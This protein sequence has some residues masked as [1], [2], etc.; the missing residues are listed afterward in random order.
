MRCEDDCT[1]D[2]YQSPSP[3]TKEIIPKCIKCDKQMRPHILFFDETYN[4][5][6]YR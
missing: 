4:E 3:D 5:K 6:Y 1:D 2:L